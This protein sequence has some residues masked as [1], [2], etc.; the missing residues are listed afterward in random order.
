MESTDKIPPVK[1][2]YLEELCSN[3]ELDE[4]TSL[5]KRFHDESQKEYHK[6]YPALTPRCSVC[7]C[8]ISEN[9]PFL[10]AYSR[11]QMV[12]KCE[13]CRGAE[14][15]ILFSQKNL[16]KEKD[17]FVAAFIVGLLFGIPTFLAFYLPSFSAES[18]SDN[19]TVLCILGAALGYVLFST[20]F[21]AISK[22]DPASS[23]FTSGFSV[24]LSFFT[25]QYS[26][27]DLNVPIVLIPKTILALILFPIGFTIFLA[28]F[29]VSAVISIF[30]FPFSVIRYFV[31]H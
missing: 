14:K 17:R 1:I 3:E 11:P 6:K 28:C 24:G 5:A 18:G 20:V 7:G 8:K 4:E 2:D 12:V 15:V 25:F 13:E 27:T 9:S 10:K 21:C 23:I 30:M 29:I 26:R 22:A 19:R 16:K 31:T